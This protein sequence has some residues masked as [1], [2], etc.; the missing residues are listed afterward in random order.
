LCFAYFLLNVWYDD[1][2]SLAHVFFRN[3]LRASRD[4]KKAVIYV[5]FDRS[6]KNLLEKLGPLI[7][8]SLPALIKMAEVLAVNVGSFFPESP[9]TGKQMLFPSADA[10]D[11]KS[12]EFPKKGIVGKLL[13]PVDFEAGA[14]PYL[15][16]IPP[17]QKISS[18]FFNHK[19][20]EVGYL[21][22]GQ[23]Q[24]HLR[25]SERLYCNHYI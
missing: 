6:P 18:H 11:V 21:M 20:Q 5:S 9:D 2:G 25:K 22:S 10:V 24:V 16:E 17:G 7:Y 4:Q 3:F 8:P 23:L 19:G 12:P 1:A 14:E 13:T 15:I